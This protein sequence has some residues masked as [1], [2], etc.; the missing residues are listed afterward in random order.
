L[1][2]IEETITKLTEL[3][4]T[5]MATA[6]RELMQTAP[7]HQLSFEEK[8]GIVVDREWTERDNRRL[9]RRLKAWH[10]VMR[11]RRGTRAT[12]SG[13][14]RNLPGRSARLRGL[15]GQFSTQPG[16][17]V[18]PVPLGRSRR[19]PLYGSGLLDG[20]PGENSELDDL[21]CGSIDCGQFDECLVEVEQFVADRQR[22]AIA[23]GE[24]A[25][26]S[27]A[28]MTLAPLLPRLVDENPPH[29]FGGGGE[30]VAAGGEGRRQGTG[31]RS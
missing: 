4:L 5:S 16:P 2:T 22:D 3:R 8:L 17:G 18:G 7:G 24:L 14:F 27:V 15:G 9:A 28:T 31:V 20:Q 29:R 1:T 26:L 19:N 25:P 30:K 12:D 6:I 13:K 10:K 21:G 11:N 23:V